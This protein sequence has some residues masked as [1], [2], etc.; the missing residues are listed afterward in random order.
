M[1][2]TVAVLG[3]A[4]AAVG[5]A[6]V[7]SV[8]DASDLNTATDAAASA[9]TSGSVVDGARPAPADLAREAS[10]PTV[11]RAGT[12]PVL[13][14]LQRASKSNAM[15]VARQD[16]SGSVTKTVK[17]VQPVEQVQSSDPRDIAMGML[18]DYGWSSDQFSCL[19]EIYLH[20]SGWD[21][22]AANPSSGAYGIPQAL[23]GDKMA[24]YGADWQTNPTTQ[25]QWGLAY[26]QDRYGTPC[27]A[28]GFWQSNNWY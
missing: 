19:N 18:S 11:S 10:D 27:G 23:P 4:G 13:A 15:P 12:R 2:A 20:E 21:P 26:I 24:S 5:V 6:M 3:T 1:T 9:S 22:S 16:V 17:T 28:W 7:T 8:G 14:S 25:L